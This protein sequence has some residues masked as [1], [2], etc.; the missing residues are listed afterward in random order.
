MRQPVVHVRFRSG[1]LVLAARW[2]QAQNG[3]VPP[4][5]EAEPPESP[6]DFLRRH[7][8]HELRRDFGRS[9]DELHPAHQQIVSREGYA[10]CRARLFERAGVTGTFASF[11]VLDVYD[12]PVELPEIP[13]VSSKAVRV[14]FEIRAR[15]GTETVEDTLHAIWIGDRWAWFLRA[16]VKQAYEQGRCPGVENGRF[17]RRGR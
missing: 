14:R 4:R 10:E 2:A 1:R 3:Y 8:E 17:R 5:Q 12:E 9:W 16:A 7:L 15:R 13:E 6:G 11:D